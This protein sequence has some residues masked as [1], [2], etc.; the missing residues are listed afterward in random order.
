MGLS[1]AKPVPCLSP[2]LRL[3]KI[4]KQSNQSSQ[5]NQAGSVID[6]IRIMIKVEPLYVRKSLQRRTR[7]DTDTDTRRLA[8][9][10]TDDGTFLCLHPIHVRICSPNLYLTVPYILQDKNNNDS[11]D[12]AIRAK[13]K[14][15]ATRPRICRADLYLLAW[16]CKR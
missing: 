6:L 5:T 12:R 13:R 10:L 9:L 1:L 8:L 2:P 15:Y 11:V 7:T 3:F 16:K 14:N 4:T